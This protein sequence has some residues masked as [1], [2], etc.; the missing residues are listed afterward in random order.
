MT[1]SSIPASLRL[2]VIRRAGKRCEYCRLHQEDTAFTLEIN[3]VV[4]VK[5]GGQSTADNLSLCCLPCNRHKGSDLATI[6]P[7]SR[8]IGLLF[9][10]RN[11]KWTDQFR[12]DG[13]RIVG[14]TS[15]GR[16]T[17]ALLQMNT[18]IQLVARQGAVLQGR[19][20]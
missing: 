20:P 13:A 9:N 19:Y 12:L 8:E 11:Q 1:S 16:A 2:L 4:A 6:D 15:T 10:P 3:H 5:H 14:I 17:V 18:L 7:I